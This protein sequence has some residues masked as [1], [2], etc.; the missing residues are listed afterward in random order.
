[1]MM[2]QRQHENQG[3]SEPYV[4]V[5]CLV[6]NGD[7]FL[8]VKRSDSVSKPGYWKA[9]GGYMKF[10]ETPEQTAA[11]EVQEETGLQISNIK[12]R[13]ITNDIFE[14]EKK[15]F[16]TIW[17]VTQSFSGEAKVNAPELSELQWSTWDFLPSPLYLPLQHLIEGK[18][19]PSQTTESK[20]GD[21]VE[22]PGSWS[23]QFT[24]QT[25]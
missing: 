20:I 6:L 14:D 23:E 3:E 11:R 13:C 24:Q 25:Q 21:S 18:T 15:Q 19:Y 10:G 7:R 5:S 17:M 16:I 9:P 22:T 2:E 8:L 1:M 4:G 12:F